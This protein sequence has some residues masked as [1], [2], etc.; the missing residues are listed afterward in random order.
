MATPELAFAVEGAEAERFAA[1]PL[2]HLRLRVSND[3]SGLAIRNVMLQCQVRI[4][5]ARRKYEAAE[6]ARLVELFGEPE[7][8]SRTLQSLL[9]ANTS[10]LVPAF[11]SACVVAL[12][13]P[14]TF[15]FNVAVTKY[16]HGL[17][18]GEVPLVLLFS[19]TV[20]YDDGAGL[21]IGQIPWTQEVRYRLPVAVWQS[22]M[23]HYY[24]DSAWLRL[25]SDVFERLRRYREQHG[26][27]DW[28]RTLDH[29]LK[30]AEI[31]ALT[32]ELER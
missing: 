26:L 9:W 24:P 3:S 6:Q 17:E 12:P 8:W 20:F 10:V 15:D 5:P 32:A 11:D 14:C 7:R 1:A 2:I 21:Q 28:E 27:V 30:G 18:A 23:T 16:V 19:G 29:L 25:P 22:M 13:L 31:G 4:E